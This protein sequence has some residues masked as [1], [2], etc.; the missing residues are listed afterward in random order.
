MS[1]LF[2]NHSFVYIWLGQAASGFG[3]VFA[4]FIMSWLAYEISGSKVVLSSILALEM[5]LSL[6]V[7]LWSGPYLD[8]WDRKKVMVVSQW[9]RAFAFLIPTVLFLFDSL[10]VWHLYATAV[11][12][13]VAEP[14]YRPSSMAYVAKLLPK[15][16]LNSANAMLE[17][18]MQTLAMIGPP[19][20]GLIL[21][22]M[23]AEIVLAVLVGLMG[24]S[25]LLLLKLEKQENENDGI[26]MS[27]FAQFK[28][29]IQFYRVH[30]VF[31]GIGLLILISN[32]AH[33]ALT[34]MFL[35][36]IREDL[37]GTSFQY[38]LFTSCFSIGMLLGSF[39][40]GLVK[41][42]ENRRRIMLGAY[43]LHGAFMVL[44]GVFK[45]YP[46]L[47][48]CIGGVGFCI[49][50]FSV[51][52]TTMYQKHVPNGLIGRVFAVRII[53]A[54]AGMP[55]GALIGGSFAEKIGIP[56]LFNVMGLLIVSVA[57]I[58]FFL[59]VF[60]RLNESHSGRPGMPSIKGN[61]ITARGH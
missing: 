20:A 39:V 49:I 36:F 12:I 61:E 14:L 29:G 51:N 11:L 54:Q 5:G 58:A 55:A 37:G 52:N 50:V 33:A 48:L 46:L 17:G 35:P 22:F 34:P 16:R 41:E 59:P 42:P 9:L 38:G 57:L 56:A 1:E 30:K 8:R 7:Q 4:A 15:D 13:G 40:T 32:M 44:L 43:M 2:R 26:G 21:M 19:V 18:T 28:Q 60:Y 53:L 3:G 47:L 23:G 6:V 10:H 45:L 25:G 24:V 27:W 31:L